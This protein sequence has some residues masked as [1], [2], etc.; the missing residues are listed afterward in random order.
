MGRLTPCQGFGM[1]YPL[2]IKHG[3]KAEP[4]QRQSIGFGLKANTNKA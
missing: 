3:A 2:S 4:E 1:S